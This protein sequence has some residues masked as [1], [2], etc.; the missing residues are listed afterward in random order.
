MA[1]YQ[2]GK[3]IRCPHC[4]RQAILED[5]PEGYA[6][7]RWLGARKEE[8]YLRCLVCTATFPLWGIKEY[9]AKK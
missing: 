5:M 1:T 7:K 6:T 2:T 4:D 3:P 8:P 9:C